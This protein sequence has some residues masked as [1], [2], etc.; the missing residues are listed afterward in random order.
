MTVTVLVIV[1]VALVAA[2]IPA[3]RAA[4]VDPVD[5]LR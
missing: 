4:R 3:R 2:L 5:S 1:A